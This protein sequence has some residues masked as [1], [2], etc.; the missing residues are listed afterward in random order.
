M[1][2]FIWM[3]RGGSFGF[4]F[5]VKLALTIVAILLCLYDWKRNKRWDYFWVFLIG[6]LIWSLTEVFNQLSGQRH[7]PDAYL[8][9]FQ[10]PLYISIP[11]QGTS[12]AA[13]VA[14]LGLFIA[15]HL[16]DKRKWIGGMI[17]ILIILTP[18]ALNLIINGIQIPD[19]GNPLIPSRRQMFTPAA[20]IFLA[21]MV[22]I[23]VVW[24]WKTTPEF[25]K[26]GYLLFISMLII[27]VIFTILE[28]VGGTRWI[29]MGPVGGPWIRAPP[30]IEFGALTYDI[31]VEIAA[32]YMPFLAI[33][34][35][36]RL[37]K[38]TKQF[39]GDN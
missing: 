31:V 2:D 34:C 11:L 12:E 36:L 28:W 37:I 24:L 3:I 25:R 38:P 23:A 15:D 5:N 33:P 4:D 22:I 32:A 29:E 20:T 16:F 6:A 27:A 8:F 35:A 14:V 17:G 26:R 21:V 7:M 39:K 13:F 9:G 18:T 10:L 19:V 30:P 1:V